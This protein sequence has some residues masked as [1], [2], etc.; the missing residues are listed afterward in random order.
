MRRNHDSGRSLDLQKVCH[1]TGARD[2]VDKAERE[3]A[4]THASSKQ[5]LL[6]SNGVLTSQ[7]TSHGGHSEPMGHI[8]TGYDGGRAGAFVLLKWPVWEIMLPLECRSVR[9]RPEEQG[10]PDLRVSA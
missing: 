4:S 9:L 6:A 3:V 10:A 8:G 1:E 7:P 2:R 5:E